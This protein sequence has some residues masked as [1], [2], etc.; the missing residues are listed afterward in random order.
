MPKILKILEIHLVHG[1]E[2]GRELLRGA[3]D[4]RVHSC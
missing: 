4:V 3:I 1:I 2:L